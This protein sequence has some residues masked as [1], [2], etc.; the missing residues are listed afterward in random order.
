M[1]KVVTWEQ[2]GT[3]PSP[4]EQPQVPVSTP[5]AV[6]AGPRTVTFEDLG[7][8]PEGYKPP[9]AMQDLPPSIGSGAAQGAMGVAG[10]PGALTYYTREY[11]EK[12]IRRRLQGE[13]ATED[14]ARGLE[15]GMTREE[16]ARI[17][18]GSA[19]PFQAP[20]GPYVLPTMQGMDIWGKEN[21]P[22]YDYKSAT[23]LGETAQ[24]GTNFAIQSLVGG[25]KGAIRR[26]VTGAGAGAG[27]ENVGQI[28]EAVGGET[29]KLVG[30]IGGAVLGDILTHKVV[31][32]GKNIGFTTAESQKQIMDAVAADMAANPEL[33]T[34]L[35]TAIDSGEPIY[36]ADFLQGTAAR[37]L[38]GQ[39]FSP[40]Q[41]E[42]MLKINR[43][44]EKRA[45]GIQDAVDDKFRLVVGRNLRDTDFATAI[46]EANN[47]TREKLYTDLKALPNAQ[48]VTSQQLQTLSGS[49]GYVREAI[50][51]VNKQFREGKISPKWNVNPPS[52]AGPGN[53]AYWD[54][55][56]REID[57]TI[58]GAQKGEA[59]GN[60]LAGA[61]NA[62]Q[63]LVG[64]LDAAVPEYGSVRNQAAEMFGAETS[65]EGGYKMAQTLAAGSPFKV[66]EFMQSYKTLR[67]SEKNAF[68][69]GAARFML[70]KANGDMS[71]LLKYMDNPNVS[72]TLKGVLGSDKYDALYA[73]AVS[74]NLMSNADKFAY[75]SSATGSKIRGLVADV[76][77]GVAF[78]AP[79]IPASLA[80]GNVGLNLA[81]GAAIATGALAGIAMNASERKVANRVVELAFSTDPKDAKAFS[82]L[83]SENYDAVNVSRKIGDYLYSGS[84]KAAIAYINNQREADMP[85]QRRSGGR[86]AR[87][88]GGRIGVNSIS[89]EVKKVR[90]LLSEKTASM[91]SIPDDAIATALHIAKRT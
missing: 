18:E 46:E 79:T 37:K 50:A 47:R 45:G 80:S 90:A 41:Q 15:E 65:L 75:T 59:S 31:D 21:I 72:S 33:R 22:G 19:T 10:I 73:K 77:G 6:P 70:Q 11:V 39:S 38:I 17:A 84:Q 4:A 8:P 89:A 52:A 51:A 40:S 91:L 66:G 86:V 48:A 44:I 35:K 67:P 27:S 54:L 25:P 36:L 14:W 3:P 12:P 56:K 2:L 64:A 68:A 61:T 30:E 62:K 43:E 55:V 42:A 78:A 20:G 34:R 26:F 85:P 16:R 5:D 24:T 29:G 60:I 74:A 81:S 49:N 71:G 7:T 83:L 88:A 58:R 28:G 53:L 82:K 76:A 63:E 9:T 69:Q 23:Q 1:G 32:F 13:Q 87:K 57:H